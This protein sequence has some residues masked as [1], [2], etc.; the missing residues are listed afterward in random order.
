[1]SGLLWILISN[2]YLILKVQEYVC[3]NFHTS[4]DIGYCWEEVD[5]HVVKILIWSKQLLKCLQKAILSVLW[6]IHRRV[7]QVYTVSNAN[8]SNGI[9][10]TSNL[11]WWCKCT[12]RKLCLN[13]SKNLS[14]MPWNSLNLKVYKWTV[15]SLA[16]IRLSLSIIFTLFNNISLHHSASLAK[17]SFLLICK[18]A[19][20]DKVNQK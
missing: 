12:T 7:M 5:Y 15:F 18:Y 10:R 8:S 14:I 13:R 3:T 16:T 9:P 17:Y 4:N 1:M 11:W 6:S 20:R 19:S 2:N